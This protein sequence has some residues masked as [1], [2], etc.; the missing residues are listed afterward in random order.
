MRIAALR[1]LRDALVDSLA[2]RMA[3]EA[4]ADAAA[5]RVFAMD[6]RRGME[7]DS[8]RLEVAL[9]ASY[10]GAR[11]NGKLAALMRGQMRKLR[12]AV[13]REVRAPAST[14]HAAV[15]TASERFVLVVDA[16]VQGLGVHDAHDAAKQLADVAD[17]LAL[18]SSQ[19][20]RPDA[21]EKDRGV[22]RMAASTHV[23]RGGA[24][25]MKRFGALGR[26]LGGIVD[27]DL[28]R[29]DRASGAS[30]FF[31]AELA[32]RDLAAR[33]RQ[34][35]PSFGGAKGR[36]GRG[37][38]ESGGGR[39]TAGD[40][41]SGEPDEAQKAFNEAAGELERLAQD[42][43]G[44][45]GKTEQAL[46]GG[47]TE[48]ERKALLDEA[49]KHADAIR[50]ATK[51]L[52]NVGGGS[53][54]WTSKGAAG[55]EH[56][57]HQWKGASVGP[58]GHDRPE[59]KHGAKGDGRTDQKTVKCYHATLFATISPRSTGKYHTEVRKSRRATALV[60]Y[61]AALRPTHNSHEDRSAAPRKYHGPDIPT[62]VGVRLTGSNASA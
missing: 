26:D 34:P 46:N 7:D 15:V 36:S 16:V 37:G 48:E 53:D 29:V 5:K 24:A 30:D 1:K 44:E 2:A 49:K 18:G 39:G 55:K 17:D 58:I 47:E 19:R 10:A 22:V 13:E 9:T 31:H 50:E 45:M 42:H 6:E 28:M 40:D 8:E 21:A 3:R 54:S 25:A 52:P 59:R 14:A 60:R 51:P 62:M 23:L 12:D 35:D 27:G 4:P 32:A 33:L 41:A 43:A 56:A 57:E 61:R 38:G 20:A 11:V